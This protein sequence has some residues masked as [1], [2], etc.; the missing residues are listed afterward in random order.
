MTQTSQ[1]YSSLTGRHIPHLIKSQWQLFLGVNGASFRR[2]L[3]ILSGKLLD[4][5]EKGSSGE[6]GES[7]HSE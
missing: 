2:N 6:D 4:K 5:N 3:Y 1:E 7:F